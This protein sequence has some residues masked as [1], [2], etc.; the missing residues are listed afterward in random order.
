[1][2]TTAPPPN[3]SHGYCLFLQWGTQ[4]H[5][6]SAALSTP[7]I[8][9][10]RGLGF[11]WYSFL[12]EKDGEHIMLVNKDILVPQT[13][14]GQGFRKKRKTLHFLFLEFFGYTN[15]SPQKTGLPCWLVTRQT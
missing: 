13:R 1:M 15:L 8:Q 14:T 3:M 6:V 4:D 12:A 10:K 5:R 9:G 2:F 11:N 7:W